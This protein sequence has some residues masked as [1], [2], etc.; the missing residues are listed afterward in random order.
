MSFVCSIRVFTLSLLIVSILSACQR[1]DIEFKPDDDGTP[2]TTV[3]KLNKNVSGLRDL[4]EACIKADSIAVFNIEYNDDG[5]VLYWLSMK[6]GGDTELYSEIVS[7]E[8]RVPEL[9]MKREG[10]LF[11][12]TVNGAFLKDS[13]GDRIS[14]TD[15]AKPISFILR[16]ESILC[17]IRKTVVGEFP[18]TRADYLARDVAFDYDL[19]KREYSFHLSSGYSASLP[20]ISA[21]HLLEE[22]VLNR[23]FYKDVFLDAGIA[24]TSRKSLAAAKYLGL[25][26][27]GIS[28]P[29]SGPSNEDRALETAI[30]T[31]EPVDLNGRLLYPDGQPRY[32]LLF[33][34]GGTSTSHGSS[35]GVKGVENMRVFVEKGGSYVGTCAGAFLASN[36]YDDQVDYRFYIS[37]WPGISM[38]TQLHNKRFGMFIEEDSPLLQYYDFGGDHYVDSIRHNNGAFPMELLPGTEVLARYDYPKNESVHR[39]PSIWAYKKSPKSGRVIMEGSHP[40]EVK[41]GERRDLTAAM[42]LYA[43]DGVGVTTLKGYLKNGEERVMN[44]KSTDNKPDYT[45]IGDLQAHHFAAYIPSNAKNV[46]VEL[47]SSSDCDLALMMSQDSFAFADVAEY[48]SAVP[49]ANQKLSFPAIREGLWFIAVQCLTTVTVT[50]TD[51]GQAYSGKTEVLNG[52]PYTISISWE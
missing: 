6:A 1:S 10:N 40:E 38:H 42:L 46:R 16:D 33:V 41:E 43:I 39:Q 23:S 9:S 31:G 3:V 44:K 32:R 13:K 21:F 45:C 50:E 24:L 12:W 15:P 27:E 51:Y 17:R 20:T 7:E 36:G 37:A 22:K 30:I 4:A 18:V 34:N 5:S 49:G 25:S 52:V 47:K 8:L 29:Y 26:L 35:L 19:D 2:S 48:R 28:M 11:Y 14:V